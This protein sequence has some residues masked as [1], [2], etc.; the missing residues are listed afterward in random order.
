MRIMLLQEVVTGS[1]VQNARKKY[2]ML[3]HK[4]NVPLM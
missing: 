1:Y 2:L 3:H 4:A